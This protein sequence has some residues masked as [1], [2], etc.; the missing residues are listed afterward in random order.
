MVFAEKVKFLGFGGI[1]FCTYALELVLIAL[2][3]FGKVTHRPI[4]QIYWNKAAWIIHIMAVS[5]FLCFLYGYFIEPYWL[6]VNKF[7]LETEKLSGTSFRIVHITDL[8]CDKKLRNEEKMMQLVNALEADVIVFT[9]DTI[10]RPSAMSRFQETLNRLEAK[11]GK[12]AVRGNLEVWYWRNLPVFE[13]TGFDVLDESVAEINKGGEKLYVAGLSFEHP[14][15]YDKVLSEVPEDVFSVFLYHYP[16]LIEDVQGERADLYLCGHTHGGQVA[17]PF[18]GAI[19]TL[20]KYGKKY[21]AGMYEVGDTLLYVNRGLGL[22]SRWL[23]K[24]RFFAR[25]EIAVFDI[26]PKKKTEENPAKI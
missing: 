4:A 9:G 11:L 1:I 21:E 3:V 22:D 2:F 8:H 26:L 17:L 10:N 25:P 23:P 20:T 6:K 16:D 5:G 15:R 24:V 7:R 19:I 13:N 12:Y 18:Y 14:D